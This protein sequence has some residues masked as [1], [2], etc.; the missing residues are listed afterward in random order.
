MK[1]EIERKRLYKTE[2]RES[3]L[4]Y[5][6]AALQRKLEALGRDEDRIRKGHLSTST[7][8]MVPKI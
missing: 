8:T 3:S 4:V 5:E 7:V 1:L 2:E 6:N